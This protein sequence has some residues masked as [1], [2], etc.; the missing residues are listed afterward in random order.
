MAYGAWDVRVPIVHGEKLREAL[1]PHNKN[2]Q[3]VVYPTEGHGWAKLE[4]RIDFWQR[5][6]AFLGQHLKAP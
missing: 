5:V 1:L 2:V 6:E 3:W 4:T